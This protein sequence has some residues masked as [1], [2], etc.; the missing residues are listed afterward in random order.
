MKIS[1]VSPVYFGE[2]LVQE[3]VSRIIGTVSKI[4]DD[5][6]IILVEDGSPD[7]S[8]EEIQNA[9]RANK[10]VKGI[11]L[12]RNFGQHYAITAGLQKASGDWVVVM[13]CDLQDRPEE[14]TRLYEKAQ[15]GYDTVFAQREFR[16]DSFIK[17]ISSKIFYGLFSYLTDSDQDSSVANFGI[18]HQKVMSSIL[19]MKD[20]VRYFPTMVQ[21]V[22]FSSTKL[23][24]EHNSRQEGKS[25]YSWAKLSKLA[26]N[27]IIAFS[28]KPLR[29][30]VRVGF[31]ISF[32]SF[33]IGLQYLYRYLSGEILVLG[34]T[35]LILSVWFL[36]GLII[37]ILG[38]IGIYL[39][40]TFDRVKDRPTYIIHKEINLDE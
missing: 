1:I 40:T 37:L 5:Y 32:I 17:R 19:S 3:L 23:G 35:S 2:K 13:D 30:T 33:I 4:T 24:V 18:Y 36:S 9:C 34:Y 15:E 29:L 14:I 16:Q 31:M 8:W 20:H 21:W 7:K 22:G 25:S 6:E 12:S 27:N 39:G 11:K 38:I 28:N 26:I 10:K